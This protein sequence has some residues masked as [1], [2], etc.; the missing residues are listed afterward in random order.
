MKT[1]SGRTAVIALWVLAA[2]VAR[3]EAVSVVG[4]ITD[5]TGG[6]VSGA[7]IEL[8]GP[9]GPVASGTTD[10]GGRFRLEGVAPGGY[11]LRVTAPGFEAAERDVTVDAAS[12]SLTADVGLRLAAFA[13]QVDVVAAAGYVRNAAEL[14]VS[15]S[16]VSR[17][18]A[19]VAPARSV[20]GLLRQVASV[21]LQ[22]DDADAVHPL[23]PSMAMRGLGVGDTADRGLVLV[24]GLPL[25]SGFFGNV[26]WNRVPK[27]TIERVEVV[28]GASSSLFGS[29]AMGGV[30]DVITHVPTQR[31]TVAEVQYGEYDRLQANLYHGAS[32]GQGGSYSLNADLV[33]TDGYY[34]VPE[35]ERRPVDEPQAGRLANVQGRI[36]GRPSDSVHAFL[37]AGYNDQARHGG[38]QNQRADTDVFDVAT[39]VGLDLRSSGRLDLRLMYARENFDVRNVRVVDDT[40]AFVANPHITESNDW[41]LSALW[42]KPSTGVL[43]NVTA[44]ADLRRID[45]SDEQD[46]LNAPGELDGHIRGAGVQTS[47]GIFGQ[48]SL[49]PSSRSEI[50]AGVRVDRFD[51]SDGEIARDGV[52][53]SVAGRDFTTASPRVA[54]RGEIAR[55]VSL[56][57]AFFGGFRAPTLA[58]LYR[59]FESPSFRGLSNPDLQEERLWGGDVGV[60]IARGRY[61]AQVNGFYNRLRNFVGSAEVGDVDEKYT[62]QASNVAAVRSRGF[63]V[64]GSLRVGSHL[65]IDANYTF[66]DAVVVEGELTGNVVEGAPRHAVSASL[67][68]LDSRNAFSLR[69]RYLSASFQDISNEA[70]QDARFIVDAR[71][72]RRVGRS[73]TLFVV[74]E[75]LF[76]EE[77]VADGF[78]PTL[79]APR[80]ISGGL[81]ASF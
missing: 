13:Q 81:R 27:E 78:G 4:T 34:V 43:A 44:G 51:N 36:D 74:G 23:V 46:V 19:L 31:E 35:D 21:Q 71:L 72:E 68:F 39:G 55:G 70:P 25:N 60:E 6:A 45:G 11:R 20:D 41:V 15:A 33:D 5:P 38:Y 28:R 12:P 47:A 79:G 22:G 40:T 42:S 66:T 56:R 24:D 14:P 54:A 57:G 50:L 18:V 59:S 62:V 53:R 49:R 69:S 17:E 61:A 37:R 26:A 67:V 32:L 76:D 2:G 3:A 1:T 16:V 29:F 8:A 48:I 80:Q 64:M 30:V 77:Y 73:L 63:E 7:R 9:S 58:E 52:A 65:T 10:A 75:N